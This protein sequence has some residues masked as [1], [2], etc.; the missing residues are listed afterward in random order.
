M[1][2]GIL[3]QIIK[4][5]IYGLDGNNIYWRLDEETKEK[6][7]ANGT[8]HDIRRNLYLEIFE[9]VV[10]SIWNYAAE[11]SVTTKNRGTE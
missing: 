4:Y 5:K 2:E 1:E 3:K 10:I 9:E 6:I 8:L 11:L 7:E